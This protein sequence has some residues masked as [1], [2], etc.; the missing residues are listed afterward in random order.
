MKP[1]VPF[2]FIAALSGCVHAAVPDAG[3]TIPTVPI[4]A[5]KEV[6]EIASVKLDDT[7]EISKV[8][9]ELEASGTLSDLRSASILYPEGTPA[10]SKDILL[11]G[12]K[13]RICIP[14][15]IE[16]DRFSIGLRTSDEVD[17][18]N[19]I[20]VRGITLSTSGGRIRTEIPDREPLRMGVALRQQGQDGVDNC[21]IPGLAITR[22]GTLIAIYDARRGRNA[23]LQ[24][25]IDICCNRSTDGGR[26]W[27]E[28]QVVMDMGEWGGL[29][30]KYNGVSDPCILV[31][32]T[33]G[34]ILVGACWMYGVID[35]KTG[36]W[37]EGLTEE[38]T[39][40]NHQWRRNGSLPGYDVRQSSQWI[41]TRSRDDG[42]TWSVPENFTRDVKP[43]EY[44][45]MINAPGAGITLEDGTLV[46][47]AQG[48]RE[49]ETHFSTLITS[50]DGGRTWSSGT[51]A[52]KDH[53]VHSNECMAVQL[54]DGSIMLNMRAGKNRGNLEEN[55]RLV[56]I[57][58]D[59]GKTW[60]EHPTSGHVLTE[61]TCQGSLL[62]HR[63]RSPDGSERD[64][65]LFFNPNDPSKRRHF[66]MK[67]SLDE[68]MTWPEE[69][70]MELD[71]GKGRGYSCMVPL[72]N[73]TVGLVY[74]GSGACLVYQKVDIA[75]ILGK[76][77]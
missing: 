41:V 37:V 69:M 68:G 29:P 53:A 11:K 61:P 17:L 8:C 21:R 62:K 26:T 49:D 30:E 32:R 67:C 39:A 44:C 6:N 10:A 18:S 3:V 1:L 45:L 51:P 15:G 31:D 24:G 12:R 60:E 36:K 22:E 57:T 73:G 77:E 43:E 52:V 55:G 34:D 28:M 9:I 50:R 75:E 54:S 40:W 65:L 16:S 33:T 13:A 14:C 7:L 38:S 42:L 66:T 76:T 71:E 63:Y 48:K 35:E 47:P 23:D 5:L 20:S 4:L 64:I 27:S 19:R 72:D 74:E 25:D 56:Y 70:W 2:V 59:L 46:F 58:R